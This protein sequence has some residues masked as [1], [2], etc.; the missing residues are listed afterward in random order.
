MYKYFKLSEF[1]SPDQP[2][3]GEMMEAELVEMLDTARD[4]AGFPFIITS[5]FRTVAYNRDLITRGYAA[6]PKSSH[7]LGLAVD[8]AVPNGRKRFL[9]MEALL[10]AGFT[11]FGIGDTFLHVDIDKNKP[12]NTIWTY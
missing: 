1:D 6:S 12:A 5:G 8:L 10:D 3:S 4:I 2:G 11:R 9:M 7:L